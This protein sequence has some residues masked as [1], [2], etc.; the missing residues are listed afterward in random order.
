[1]T[2]HSYLFTINANMRK[3]L[4]LVVA[5][6]ASSFICFA[7]EDDIRWQEGY[8]DIH[9]MHTGGG[10]TSFI[11]FPD[12]TTLLYDAGD[13]R[14]SAKDPFFKPFD[15][16]DITVPER[17]A[18]YVKF[19][20]P[21]G[22]LDYA[23]ISHF[24][25]D[26]YGEVRKDTPLSA[27]GEYH[28]TGI[29]GVGEQIPI[30]HLIDR[31]YPDYNY[32]IDLIAWHDASHNN[33]LKFIDYQVRN[34][35][36]IASQLTPGVNTQI[37]PMY[38]ESAYPVFDVRNVK[39]NQLIWMGS[40]DNVAAYPFDPP[41]VNSN[42]Y[43]NENPLSIALLFTFGKFEYFVAA[44]IAGENDYPD[45]DMETPIA[46]II[47][48]VDALSL[49]HH[50]YKDAVS[51]YYLSKTEPQVIVHQA[52]HEPHFAEKSLATL[53]NHP[54]DVY[55][56]SMPNDLKRWLGRSISKNYKS[57]RGNFFIRVYDNGER[58]K[59]ITLSDESYTPQFSKVS[60][61][62]ESK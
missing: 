5:L 37:K 12:G 34:C 44:D 32:P 52:C 33:Y 40:G 54:A 24:H 35:N 19:F 50:G 7:Q 31:A 10:N 22:V 6:L 23:V 8:L 62:Y 59:V 16:K 51:S 48:E 3:I 4:V 61:E 30:G 15:D 20:A 29:V 41:L 38:D 36:M 27:N 18:D 13:S 11:I 17:I 9:F 58:F 57:T 60:K 49:N 2:E 25:N 26:H 14:G 21:N 39:V 55:T 42:G 46:N 45:Y 53:R 28:L 1:M 43:Y 47:G 56:A